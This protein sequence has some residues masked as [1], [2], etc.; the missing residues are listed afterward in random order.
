M[1]T[2]LESYH[3]HRMIKSQT[4]DEDEVHEM[5]N[6][7]TFDD[8]GS[9]IEAGMDAIEVPASI[10]LKRQNKSFWSNLIS[11]KKKLALYIVGVCVA[12]PVL[13]GIAV[14][15][16]QS[17]GK[18]VVSGAEGGTGEGTSSGGTNATP[19]QQFLQEINL[20]P[21]ST[22][23]D[24][25]DTN[26]P[27]Y[28]ALQWIES[29]AAFDDLSDPQTQL[30]LQQRFSLANVFYAM[31][32]DQWGNVDGWLE[33]GDVCT[34]N[35]ITCGGD[36]NVDNNGRKLQDNGKVV[37]IELNR[38]N[39]NGQIPPEIVLL[40][41]LEELIMFENQISGVLPSELYNIPSL[42][43]LDLYDNDIEGS[44][45][46][47]IGQLQNLVALYLGKNRLDLTLPIELFSITS[48]EAL[49]INDMNRLEEMPVG[50]D[51]PV[52]IGNLVNMKDLRMARSFFKGNLPAEIGNLVN[53]EHLDLENNGL[54]GKIPA[55][56]EECAK[57]DFLNLANNWF[58]GELPRLRN[59]PDLETLRFDG[60]ILA[61]AEGQ[62]NGIPNHYGLLLNLEDLRLGPNIFEGEGGLS[63]PIPESFGTLTK[64]RILHLHENYLTGE[65]PDSISE[66]TQLD[67]FMFQGNDITGTVSIDICDLNIPKIEADCDVDCDCCT[68]ACQRN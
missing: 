6:A 7:D 3:N 12:V 40:Q 33:D 18:I 8:D 43:I 22:Q 10:A 4:F 65:V 19:T 47:D 52:D 60:N 30:D 44:I 49:W 39:V 64:L 17:R 45:S 38:M 62:E 35:A 20:L 57:L 32:G 37:K 68:D 29:D 31:G 54:T 15:T 67:E 41:D 53:L 24:M 63:G 1:D 26:S 61:N 59:N 5:C 50:Q 21:A 48:L 42:Q 58:E 14:G 56:I 16:T 66:L 9:G 11:N 46:P 25:S 51:L 34:W 36:G 55:E 23:T 13:I 28:K 2:F 27:A